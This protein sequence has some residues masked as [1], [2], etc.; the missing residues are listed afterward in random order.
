MRITK[1][2]I[3]SLYGVE[4]LELTGKPVE[5]TGAKG[6]GKT[7]VLDAIKFALTNKSDRDY[8]I[9]QGKNEGSILIETDSGLSI[10][11]RKREGGLPDQSKILEFGEPIKSPQSFINEIFTTLQLNPIEFASWDK[12]RQN[13]AILDLIEFEWDINW[14]AQQFGEIPKGIDYNQHILQVLEDIQDKKSDYWLRREDANR[15]ELYKRQ[16][17][18]EIAK[19]IPDKYDINKWKSYSLS[20]S[21]K[22]LQTRQRNNSEIDRAVAFKESYNNKIRGFQAERDI[23]ISAEEKAIANEREGLKST[24]ERLKA[25][26]IAA[27]NKLTTL[28][29]KLKDKKDLAI[30]QYNEKVAKLE[31]DIKLAEE[32]AQKPK[33]PTED[34]QSEIDYAEDMKK[35]ISEYELMQNMLNECIDLKD[36]SNMLTS[37]IELA[38]TLPGKVLESC[39]LPVQGLTVQNGIPLINGLPISN[40]STGEKIELCV[41]VALSKPKNLQ[42]ILL[43]GIESLD[44]TNRNKLYERCKEKGLQ[45]IAARTTNDTEFN[46]IEL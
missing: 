1:I 24:I 29:D 23:A 14:I 10:S 37:K 31:G 28:D 40:L 27:E 44:E 33:L 11:R 12:N 9:K 8:V 32:Y 3:D 13:R 2:K 35:Y 17:V 6:T 18:T 22:E 4:H 43:D 20:E 34:L 16:S 41:D 5:F 46:I 38:R 39:K 30:S 21:I 7:S 25:E 45:I 19:K 15:K 42:I 26:I 36:E